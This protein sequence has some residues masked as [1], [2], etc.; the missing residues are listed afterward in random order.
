MQKTY[1]LLVASEETLLKELM[2]KKLQEEE[3]EKARKI[4]V[5]YLYNFF[6]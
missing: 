2:S 6:Y 3:A 4:K 1:K 5:Y